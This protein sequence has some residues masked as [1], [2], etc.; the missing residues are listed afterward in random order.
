MINLCKKYDVPEPLFDEYSGGFSVTFRFKMPVGTQLREN[1]ELS[2]R[3]KNIIKVLN[4]A[5]KPLSASD[6]LITLEPEASMRTIQADLKK[7]QHQNL[8]RKV[9]KA[10]NTL[11]E[12]I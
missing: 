1:T 6:I 3:E 11:C 12:L 2:Y 9:G 10:R 8:V 4:D 5:Q 7:L